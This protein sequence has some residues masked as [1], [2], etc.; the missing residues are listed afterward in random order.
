M[1][2]CNNYEVIDLGVMVPCEKI[3]ET[4]RELQ[5]D[6]IGLSGLITPSLDEMQHV[7]RELKRADMQLPLLIGGATTSELHTAVKIAPLRAAPTVYVKDASRVVGVCG[8][9]M[10][11]QTL[12]EFMQ[13]QDAQYARL[14]EQFAN[15]DRVKLMS[16]QRARAN[17]L[18]LDWQNYQP[19]VP[20]QLGVQILKDYPLAELIDYIDWS[21]FFRTW[22]LIGKYPA[23]F[24]DKVVGSEAKKL[25]AEA[26]QML[27]QI[28]A[29][30]WLTLNGVYGLFPANS[31]GDDVILYA[32][33]APTKGAGA[34][35]ELA[36]LHFV[37]QQLLRPQ[38][39]SKPN[40]CLAD[41]IAPQDSGVPDYMGMFAVTSGVNIE[42]ALAGFA[43]EDDY[44]RIMLQALADRLVEAFA[45]HLHARVRREFWGYAADEQL[46]CQQ[47]IAEC[48]QG[49]RPAPGYPACP[50]HTE[51]QSI[52]ALLDV[53]S[54][55]GISLTESMA[56]YPA[57]SICG[58]YFAHPEV[59]YFGCG[60]INDEQ[61][62]D[63][64]RRK[65]VSK[66]WLLKWLQ[67]SMA[68][69]G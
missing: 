62:A 64:A 59:K 20:Q 38:G 30:K 48:Y 34:A 32:E 41:Y 4:A 22:Q 7:A 28:V 12:P 21:P 56:M 17:K 55:T 66:E 31:C 35:R 39:S 67:S 60:K 47:L 23:I 44:Q 69:N 52:F 61:L 37:R 14:C 57:S 2:Q 65:D 6:M 58:Y 16:L 50:D 40:L 53:E 15:K 45:E 49:I 25:Y 29:G 11:P 26:Q 8:K 13:Q 36:R 18:Q 3:L 10:N 27:G 33:N 51:K 19:A 63:L 54:N 42:T 68:P 1:L 24:D 43:A 46:D 5:V 9:L